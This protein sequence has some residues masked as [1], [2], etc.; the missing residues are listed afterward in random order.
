MERGFTVRPYRDEDER[1]WVVCPVL[2]FL[3]DERRF[4][5]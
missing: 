4:T 3:L 1:G 2:S 5:K